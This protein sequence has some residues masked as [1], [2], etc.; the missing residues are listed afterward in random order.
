MAVLEHR[1]CELEHTPPRVHSL[2]HTVTQLQVQFTAM[3]RDLSEI[4]EESKITHRLVQK[5]GEE[6]RRLFFIG[7]VLAAVA[8]TLLAGLKI[9][10]SWSAIQDRDRA[11]HS[12]KDVN[13][14]RSEHHPGLA[15]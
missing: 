14:D 7:T 12:H 13:H 1:V 8:S 2:E 5:L 4:K 11:S 9:Y 10:D 6:V 3:T 15:K